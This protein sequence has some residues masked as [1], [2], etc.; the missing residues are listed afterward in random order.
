MGKSGNRIPWLVGAVAIGLVGTAATGYWVTHNAPQPNDATT[1]TVTVATQNLT[2]KIKA[3]GIVQALRKTNLSPKDGGQIM[4]LLVDEGDRVAAGQLIARTDSRQVD[5]QVNQYRALLAKAQ[6]D[7]SQKQAGVRPEEI[8]EGRAR[9]ATAAA[10]TAEAAARLNRAQAELQRNQMLAKAGAIATNALETLADKVRE[11]EANL[12]AQQARQQEQ[13]ETLTKLQNGTRPQEIAQAEAEVAQVLAQLRAQE[14][15]VDNTL[16]RA[17]FA[18]I[19]TRRFAQVGDFVTPTTSASATD[20]ATSTSIA[21]L[22]QGLEIEAKVPEASIAKIKPNQLVEIRSKTY[23]DQQFAGTVRLIAPRAVQENNVTSFRVKIALKTGK[24][25]LRSGM[26]VELAFISDPIA[27]AI[28][29]PLAVI[30]K[31]DGQDGVWIADDKQSAQ[32]RPVSLGITAGDQIQ[33]IKGL[34]TGDRVFLSP[35]PGQ[36]IPGVDTVGNGN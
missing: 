8:A 20:G 25:Q 26:N 12:A 28:T 27:N 3:N 30:T 15:L 10:T 9:L 13:A 23:P 19:I 1:Q 22:S 31:K 21:E 4:E 29:V 32:F 35:P 11:A 36:I 18:G 6:A 16:I 34:Q 33:I 14:T 7:L 5:A 24:T 17:P 2:L